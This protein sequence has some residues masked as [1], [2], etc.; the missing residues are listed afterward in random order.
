VWIIASSTPEAA[1]TATNSTYHS[2]D[3]LAMFLVFGT[4]ENNNLLYIGVLAGDRA[5]ILQNWMDDGEGA[6]NPL[7]ITNVPII[8]FLSNL[9]HDHQT[10]GW[11][12]GT[13]LAERTSTPQWV[14]GHRQMLPP[15]PTFVSRTFQLLISSAPLYRCNGFTSQGP[16]LELSYCDGTGG[17]TSLVRCQI[18]RIADI[19]GMTPPRHPNY[20]SD[21]CHEADHHHKEHGHDD[22]PPPSPKRGRYDY[23]V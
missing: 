1:T 2:T 6:I 20:A 14:W 21:A 16:S 11:L 12:T 18:V 19:P 5:R 3:C 22:S 8:R 10:G 7:P 23:G 17:H 4:E 15:R 9:I 13:F